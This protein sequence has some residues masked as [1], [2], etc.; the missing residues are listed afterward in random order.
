MACRFLSR[1]L[2][3]GSTN[4]LTETSPENPG[5]MTRLLLDFP[6]QIASVLDRNADGYFAF[7]QFER[8]CEI[9]HLYPVP[10]VAEADYLALRDNPQYTGGSNLR[11]TLQV[12]Y[13]Y[14]RE[15]GG[16]IRAAP[17][18]GPNDLSDAWKIAL[19]D[20]LH[21]NQW[22]TPQIIICK[23]RSDAWKRSMAGAR[24]KTEVV[25]RC[26]NC[27]EEY[28]RVIAVLESYEHH[29]LVRSDRDPW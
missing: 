25:L 14:I 20:E 1:R 4:Q 28:R 26:E 10:F 9:E 18:D 2:G 22:R 12:M 29:L 11:A 17:E 16:L 21:L 27:G 19:Y 15:T 8:L 24:E 5:E 7:Y 13:K 6:W 23:S 3:Y